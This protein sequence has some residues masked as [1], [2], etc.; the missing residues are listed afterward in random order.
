MSHN[1]KRKDTI[2]K[3]NQRRNANKITTEKIF[4]VLLMLHTNERE[5]ITTEK[6]VLV[7]VR[8]Q[9][10]KRKE[11]ITKKYFLYQ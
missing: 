11:V 8:L 4:L 9:M 10:H 2:G 6:I 7:P 5:E 1:L 3:E